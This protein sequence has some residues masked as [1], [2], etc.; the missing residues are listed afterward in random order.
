MSN[1][2][3][4]C[5]MRDQV[6]RL[7]SKQERNRKELGTCWIDGGLVNGTAETT[8]VTID[9]RISPENQHK[10]LTLLQA[11]ETDAANKKV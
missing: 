6:D 9:C 8:V 5:L 7:R 11:I 4:M 3:E 10:L 2:C 1:S